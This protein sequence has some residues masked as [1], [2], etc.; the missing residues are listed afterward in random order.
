MSNKPL[1]I[2]YIVNTSNTHSKSIFC[3]SGHIFTSSWANFGCFR[4]FLRPS[5]ALLGRLLGSLGALLGALWR[6]LGRSWALLARSCSRLF[7]KIRATE[8]RRTISDDFGSISVD[9]PHRKPPKSFRE[10]AK[11]SRKPAPQRR[12]PNAEQQ[13]RVRRFREANSIRR[14]LR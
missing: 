14:T 4:G 10:P 1:Q 3:S 9:F 12:A 8:L 5:W 2:K 11:S 6:L 13:M 7:P